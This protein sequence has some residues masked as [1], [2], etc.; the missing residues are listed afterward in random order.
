MY[1][2]VIE[3]T[4]KIT[5]ITI[6]YEELGQ[7]YEQVFKELQIYKKKWNKMFCEFS[8]NNEELT[9]INFKIN[10]FRTEDRKVKKIVKQTQEIRT[11]KTERMMTA[12]ENQTP[13]SLNATTKGQ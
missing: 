12:T 10:D 8:D 4:C 7:I 11:E 9:D 1:K 6:A 13:I 3:K 5:E 2:E